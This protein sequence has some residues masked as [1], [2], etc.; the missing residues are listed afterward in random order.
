MGELLLLAIGSAFYPLYLAVVIVAFATESP[1]RVLL[2][3]LVGGSISLMT[4]GIAVVLAFSGTSFADSS[5]D[6]APAGLT[7]AIG[8]LLLVAAFVLRRWKPPHKEGSGRTERMIG[9]GRAPVAAVAGLLMNAVPGPF[10]VIGLKDI[11][12][13]DY[14]T[15]QEIALVA[16]FNVFQLSLIWLPLVGGKISPERTARIAGRFEAW[17]ARNGQRILMLGCAAFG[18]YL[19]VRGVFQITG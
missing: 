11:T 19:V 3:Y 8:L 4:V 1:S 16:V 14:T 10:Y 13:G 9:S 2:G 7:I 15:A 6:T 17:L 5:H 18:V 12:V